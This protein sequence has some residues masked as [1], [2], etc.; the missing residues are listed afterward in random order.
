MGQ[1]KKEYSPTPKY[2][3]LLKDLR[4]QFEYRLDTNYAKIDR[5][6][7]SEIEEFKQ[8]ILN[9]EFKGRTIKTWSEILSS[10]NESLLEKALREII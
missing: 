3:Q 5:I 10:G 2:Q 6:E 9:S 8:K 4:S 7:H 1:E